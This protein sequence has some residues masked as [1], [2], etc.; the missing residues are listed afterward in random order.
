MFVWRTWNYE[1][2]VELDKGKYQLDF[3][4]QDFHALLTGPRGTIQSEGHVSE[5]DEAMMRR[6]GGFVW[7]TLGHL[8]LPISAI[9]VLFR[10]CRRFGKRVDPF[11]LAQYHVR[12]LHRHCAKITVVDTKETSSV[13]FRDED[14]RWGEFCLGAFDNV[15][16]R[17]SNYLLLFKFFCL[18]S[19][20]IICWSNLSVSLFSKLD[21]FPHRI[22]G[23]NVSVSYALRPC[24][25]ANKLVAI[26]RIFF[27]KG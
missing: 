19:C 6:N 1:D 5:A 23:T 7:N 22:S 12:V 11:V 2:I 15:H 20:T 14:N 9:T 24:K 17:H 18:W 25:H 10:K 13:L 27:G 16:D 21:S 8:Y 4:H 3:R 26:S